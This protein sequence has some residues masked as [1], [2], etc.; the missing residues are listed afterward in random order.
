LFKKHEEIDVPKE[1]PG[2]FSFRHR[3]A[4]C[5][6]FGEGDDSE[7]SNPQQNQS[8]KFEEMK[9]VGYSERKKSPNQ[10]TLQSALNSSMGQSSNYNLSFNSSGASQNSVLSNQ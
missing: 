8:D 2:S 10:D 7:D 5:G 4:S 3:S 6:A 9:K 1:A